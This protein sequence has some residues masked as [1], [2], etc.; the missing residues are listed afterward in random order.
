[1]AHIKFKEFPWHSIVF[2]ISTVAMIGLGV[3]GFVVP[4]LGMIDPSVFHYSSLLCVPIVVSQIKP[5]LK[6]ASYFKASVGA[7]SVEAKGKGAQPSS[8]Q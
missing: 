2:L 7:A 6:E 5:V 8:E 4:P 3:A 1:M